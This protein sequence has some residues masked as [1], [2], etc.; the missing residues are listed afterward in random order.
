LAKLARLIARV[1][2]IGPRGAFADAV[3]ENARSDSE[4]VPN[5]AP[6][7]REPYRV[8]APAAHSHDRR[9]VVH[10]IANFM[11]GGS[12]R[13]IVDLVER[14][15]QSYDHRVLTSYIPDPPAYTGI[16][17]EKIDRNADLTSFTAHLTAQQPELVHVHY[18]GDCD[19]SWYAQVFS[20]AERLGYAV[21]ENVN[22]PVQ[23]YLSPCV[24]RYVYVSRYVRESFGSMTSRSEVIYPGSDFELFSR[25]DMEGVPDDCIG[26]VYRLERDKLNDESIDPIIQAVERRPGTRA[27]IVGGGSLLE[28]FRRKV[29][30]AGLQSSF[31]FTGYV[32]YEQLPALYAQFAVFVAPVW[33]ESFGQ[34][35]P[36]AMSMG[37]PIA[38]YRVG[39]IPEIV[40]NP[41]VLAD[42]GD[43]RGLAEVLVRLL[44]D[45]SE[46]L[47]IGERNRRRAHE[48]FS[49]EAMIESYRELYGGLIEEKR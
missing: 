36:F 31:T 12:S 27:L 46:R 5:P 1:G 28:C 35:S 13:L 17:I 30:Q 41:A 49:L 16:D 18:W 9:R 21:V 42:P 20:A 29:E 22:T 2:G 23:P 37:I 43:A 11:T 4:A 44:D 38:G 6:D 24:V 45:R 15:G 8:R 26:M 48:R 10:A 40:D 7:M 39:A 34:V 32:S 25:S 33:Q 47:I 3:T 19:H 14:L